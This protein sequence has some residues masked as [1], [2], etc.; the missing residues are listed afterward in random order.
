MPIAI[1]R[2]V[3]IASVA[4]FERL[5][6]FPVL[7]Q[8]TSAEFLFLLVLAFFNPPSQLTRAL[9]NA[10]Q[11]WLP[12]GDFD[13]TL[14]GIIKSILGN[15]DQGGRIGVARQRDLALLPES[16]QVMPPCLLEA[17]KEQVRAAQQQNVGRRSIT[18]REG[19]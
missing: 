12:A 18:T 19:S 8:P 4:C 9:I 17:D 14:G 3:A 13:A 11:V 5:Q 10:D 1:F 6:L 16:D 2:A 7:P 15:P